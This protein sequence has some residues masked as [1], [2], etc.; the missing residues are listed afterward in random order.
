MQYL[1]R[2]IRVRAAL[3]ERP[4]LLDEIRAIFASHMAKDGVKEPVGRGNSRW[5]YE[6]GDLEEVAPNCTV[7]LLLKLSTSKSRNM[8]YADASRR[9]KY[10]NLAEFGAFEVYYDFVAG[11]LPKVS[12]RSA[13][14]YTR[15]LARKYTRNFGESFA[16]DEPWGG[17]R[18]GKHDYGALPYF[19][20]AVR[21]KKLFGILTEG[22]PPLIE[23]V[24][25]A[26]DR[27][28]FDDFTVERKRIIDL[29]VT[30][31]TLIHIDQGGFMLG[32]G[33]RH[34][35][36]LGLMNRAEKYFKK[37]ARLDL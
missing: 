14:E 18:V 31:S 25:T 34:P 13:K 5:A 20:M 11:I 6:V 36:F 7:K 30:Q 37:E 9:S 27:G 35:H 33:E 1:E 3:L 10:S 4:D 21:Y 23:P 29:G 8:E 12:F 15:Y 28:T 32:F 17:T 16:L 19:Q 24:G 26:N 22:E 2:T